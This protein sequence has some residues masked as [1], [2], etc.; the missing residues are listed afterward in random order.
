MRFKSKQGTTPLD[1]NETKDLIPKI[2]TQEELNLLEQKNIINAVKWVYTITKPDVLTLDFIM[3]LHN[4]M[5]N[6]VW[7]WAG[8]VRTT[9]KNIGVPKEIIYEE[10]PKML[11]DVKYWIKNKTYSW[12]EI[13]VRFHYRLICIHAFPDGNGRHA[14]LMANVLLKTNKQPQLSWSEKQDSKN[15]R[16]KYIK[17]LKKADNNHNFNDLIKFATNI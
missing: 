14:R 17:A 10:L 9:D 12:N 13:A 1:P 11:D 3:K 6:Q 8:R 4:K 2:K 7:K 16:D 5:F 15:T